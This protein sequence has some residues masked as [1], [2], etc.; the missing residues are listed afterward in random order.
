MPGR[1]LSA[2]LFGDAKS[3]GRDLSADLFGTSSRLSDQIPA[4]TTGLGTSRAVQPTPAPSAGKTWR[5]DSLKDMLYAPAE[6]VMSLGSAAAMGA[7]APVVGFAK[8]LLNGKNAKD[9]EQYASEFAQDH[10]YQPRSGTAQQLVG[11]AGEAL[12]PL[13][14]LPTAELANLH[15]AVG[16]GAAA[17]RGRV[18]APVQDLIQRTNGPM[19]AADASLRAVKPVPVRGAAMP[20][21]GA[22]ATADATLRQQRAASMPVPVPMTKGQLTRDFNQVQF[23][24]EAAKMPEGKP[25]N[26]L[27]GQQNAAMSQIMDAFGDQTGGQASS[28][29]AAGKSVVG[30]VEDKQAAKLAGVKADYALARDAGEMSDSV[31]IRPLMTYLAE[32]QTSEELAPLLKS[33]RQSVTNKSTAVPTQLGGEGVVRPDPMSRTITINDL[34]NV[35]QQIRSEAEMGTPNMAK[36]QQMISLI[37]QATDGKGG[38]LFQQARRNFENYSKEFTDRDVVDKLLRNKP[39]STDRAVAYEDVMNHTLLNGSLDDT[40]HLFRTL[41]AHPAGTDPAIVAAGQQAAKDLRGALVN[42]I[43]EQMFSNAGADSLGN[44]VGSEAKIKR[45]INELDKDGKLEAIYG[46]QGAQ[47][48][49]DVRDLA[50][51][52]YTS[53][54]GSVNT[55]NTASAAAK[56]MAKFAGVAGGTPVIGHAIK[57]TAKQIESAA[58]RKKVRAAVEPV[59]QRNQ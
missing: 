10:T 37:D 50:T 57:Y 25:L 32:N 2:E 16:S 22:A 58:M 24:R 9:P 12:A 51:D 27:Y 44:V 20:G 4:T 55:S 34:E 35:R 23:E 40:R 46:K 45:I 8:T 1:D 42:H 3:G 11:M 47:Q 52:I 54:N 49:R 41:E 5:D 15:N 6:S 36:G 53:P 19:N 13:G 56:M 30:A 18:A 21:V 31:N 48:L 26:D 7:I 33:I 29:R 28:L 17:F 59:P 38:P 39:G 14:T 43:K